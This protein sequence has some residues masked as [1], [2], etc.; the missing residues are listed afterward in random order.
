VFE[1]ALK[2]YNFEDL[3]GILDELNRKLI[4]Y[5]RT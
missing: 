1:Y 5:G 3:S 2:M 4:P